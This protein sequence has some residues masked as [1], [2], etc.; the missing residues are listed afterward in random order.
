MDR[1]PNSAGSI[2]KSYLE[3][4]E[5]TAAKASR[6]LGV[7][8]SCLSR[9]INGKSRLTSDMASKISI[10]TDTSIELWLRLQYKEDVFTAKSIIN[11]R[12]VKFNVVED[13]INE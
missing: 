13:N 1:K 3:R 6:C 10:A 9:F 5:I 4:H 8:H 12:V 7:T 11:N 2:F